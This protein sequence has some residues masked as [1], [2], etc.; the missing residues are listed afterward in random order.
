MTQ[1]QAANFQR[2]IDFIKAIDECNFNMLH[3]A[4]SYVQYESLDDLENRVSNV[5]EGHSCGSTFCAVGSIPNIFPERYSFVTGVTS[6]YLPKTRY[7]LRD[8][9]GVRDKE[10]GGITSYHKAAYELFGIE[11]FRDRS[12]I[13][14]DYYHLFASDEAT[15]RNKLEQVVYMENYLKERVIV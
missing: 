4:H 7:Y 1:E 14:S 15:N 3:H 5:S 12:C 9:Y 8:S 10:T 11:S 6:G 2:M 13:G